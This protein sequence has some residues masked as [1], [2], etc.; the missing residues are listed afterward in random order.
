MVATFASIRWRCGWLQLSL[1]AEGAGL[2]VVVIVGQG[3]GHRHWASGHHPSS[4]EAGAG[5][6]C[7]RC[8]E[9]LG[10]GGHCLCC[11]CQ[12][13]LGWRKEK[14]KLKDKKAYLLVLVCWHRYSVAGRRR[15]WEKLGMEGAVVVV[16]GG[17]S[18]G[19][20]IDIG[21]YLVVVECSWVVH[22]IDSF[23]TL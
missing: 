22:I 1:G 20:C 16:A 14:K 9:M 23:W 6:G 19:C 8:Q 11:R 12:A 10:L 5:S 18:V 3:W 2:V 15:H 7:R 4:G 21:T 13:K 17:A